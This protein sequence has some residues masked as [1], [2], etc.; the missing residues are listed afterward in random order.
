MV[1]QNNQ[2]NRI[3]F[4]GGGTGGSVS[5]LLGVVDFFRSTDKRQEYDFFWIGTANGP[6]KSMVEREGIK[7]I[8]I[9]SG[10]LRRYFSWRN[11]IDPFKVF[12]G[13]S[14][15]FFVLS[16]IKPD[17]ILSAGGFVGVP[18]VW[19]G[20]ILKIPVIIHQQ[21]VRPGL[22]NKL[23]APC[24][25]VI[26]VAF[27]KSVNDYGSKAIWIGNPVRRQM[28]RNNSVSERAWQKD[29]NEAP[30]VLVVGGSTG[31][32][33]L[34]LLIKDSVAEIAEFARIIHIT[35]QGKDLGIKH[36][37]YQ[38][39]EFLNVEKMSQALKAADIVISRSGLN[40][41]TELAYLAK[42]AIVIPISNSHQEENA[43]ILADNKAALV[44]SERNLKPM[45]FAQEIKNLISNKSLQRELSENIGRVMKKGAGE[46]LAKIIIKNLS[47]SRR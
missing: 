42:P 20:R 36:D 10:K 7:F 16:K 12:V 45:E 19:A 26:T 41:L 1:K 3:L 9:M 22:A 6:E 5:P 8:P 43:K 39:F 30:L 17:I 28:T 15:S 47:R 18:V 21:D 23:M 40:L 24:A 32:E 35:G 2:K 27:E 11:F 13:F 33:K 46:T 37:N 38:A 14:Q 34:N 4:A 44:L 29:K 31:A 25:R